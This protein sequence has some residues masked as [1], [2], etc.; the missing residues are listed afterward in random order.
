MKRRYALIAAVALIPTVARVFVGHYLRDLPGTEPVE[1]TNTALYIA[2][3][4]AL[5]LPDVHAAEQPLSQWHG[6]LLII[7]FWATWC[8]PFREEMPGFS[9]LQEKYAARGVQFVGIA[10]DTVDKVKEFSLPAPLTYPLLIASPAVMPML[11]G[12]GDPAVGLPFSL[13][14]GRD[15]SLRQSRLGVW[16]ETALEQAI[17]A[18]LAK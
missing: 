2:Q 1:S 18:E 8:A 5:T 9:R 3:L 13:M 11:A 4:L 17:L 6:K 16:P 14:L 12:L 10:F 15:G 7:N